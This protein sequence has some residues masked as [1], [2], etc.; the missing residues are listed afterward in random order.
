MLLIWLACAPYLQYKNHIQKKLRTNGFHHEIIEQDGHHISYWVKGEGRKAPL[1]LVHGF[2]GSG[3]MT[4]NR[5]IA[6]VSKDR[7]V[8]LPDLLWFGESYSTQTPSLETQAHALS[9]I[10]EKE[11]WV[12]FDLVG[13]SYGGFV[14]LEYSRT[15]QSS[16][17]KLIVLDSPGPVFSDI[18]VEALNQRFHMGSP[19][20]LFVPKKSQD[21]QDLVDI[22]FYRKQ[23]R[24]PKFF[25][26]ELWKETSFS[27]YQQ[28]K[29]DMLEQLM[30]ARS[31]YQ[32]VEWHVD[33]ILWGEFDT[34][35]PAQEALELGELTGATVDILPQTAHC[36]FVEKP[37][38]FLDV[39][40]PI[41]DRV[42][43]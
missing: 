5:I 29:I 6:K 36:P 33:H 13:T 37:E 15:H 28:E 18:D 16:I 43:K 1:V 7:P 32:G 3:M 24:I 17:Q 21:I 27:L 30:N 38:E 22:C 31:M 41:L 34:I 39:F 20:D 35:F 23:I 25:L 40:L 10:L 8:L 9:L 26:D 11:D 2:G 12:S 14:S 42:G 19:K 4:W